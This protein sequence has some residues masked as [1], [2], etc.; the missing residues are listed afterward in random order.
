MSSA[1]V[2]NAISDFVHEEKLEVITQLKI[3]LE[4]KMDDP[5]SVIEMIEEF[6]L[7]LTKVK[8]SKKGTKMKSASAKNKS[9]RPPSH[10]NHYFT[11]FQKEIKLENE[12]KEKEAENNGEEYEPMTVTERTT[13]VA[14]R[15][16]SFKDSC[17]DYETIKKKW[18]KQR[19]AQI[20]TSNNLD[21]SDNSDNFEKIKQHK[22]TTSKNNKKSVLCKPGKTC[23]IVVD[24]VKAVA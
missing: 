4:D 17:D 10:Y 23:G 8:I 3:F 13:E 22:K 2:T 5:Q 1:K 12:K 16:A 9:K 15:W 11:I 21:N 18:M 7:T 24:K 20:E 6:S 19:D 14:K